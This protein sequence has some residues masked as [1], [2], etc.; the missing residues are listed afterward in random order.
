MTKLNSLISKAY[1]RQGL[2]H[3]Q[4]LEIYAALF[5]LLLPNFSLK[6]IKGHQDTNLNYSTLH[7]IA[8]LNV[9]TDRIAT[10]HTIIPIKTYVLSS[11]SEIYIQSKYIHHR[12]DFQIRLYS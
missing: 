9:T 4:E 3:S 6:H 10:K 1:Y 2:H 7:I 5:P 12:I 11:P 8:Q